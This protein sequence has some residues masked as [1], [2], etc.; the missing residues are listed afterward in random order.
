MGTVLNARCECG[1]DVDSYVGGG[2]SD[3]NTNCSFPCLCESCNNLVNV[4]ML[5]QDKSCPLCGAA[6]PIPY[7]TPSLQDCA[8]EFTVASSNKQEQLG[9]ILEIN[10]GDYKCPSCG[11]MSLKFKFSGCWD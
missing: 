10:S 5:A 6:D 2:M 11:N 4:N 9:R 3:F 7:D 1:V 8:G